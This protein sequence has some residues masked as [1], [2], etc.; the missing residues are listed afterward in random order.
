M[1]LILH[2][3]KRIRLNDPSVCSDERFCASPYT[4]NASEKLRKNATDLTGSDVSYF[5]LQTTSQ[6]S[7]LHRMHPKKIHY[8]NVRTYSHSITFNPTLDCT[9][10]RSLILLFS[11]V[12]AILHFAFESWG[13]REERT[14]DCIWKLNSTGLTYL[15]FIVLRPPLPTSVEG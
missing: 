7:W 6:N 5:K 4:K 8:Y 3:R 15:S 13:E 12:L 10:V 2:R 9:A 11:T 14:E 1:S